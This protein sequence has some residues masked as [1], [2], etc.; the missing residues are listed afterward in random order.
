[1]KK[2]IYYVTGNQGKFEEVKYFIE[3]HTQDIDL[4]QFNAQIPEIQTLDQKTIALDKA[5]KAWE[6]LQ[7]PLIID[8][9]AIYFEKYNKFP[10]TFSKYVYQGLGFE[11]IKKLIEQKDK[12]TFFLYMIYV[13]KANSFNI[14]EGKCEGTLTK[15]EVFSG[16][17][18]LP[19][20]CFFIPHGT[21]KTYA[22]MRNTPEG[23]NY[24][25]RIKALKNFLNWWN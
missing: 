16:N 23:N 25:Y 13:E 6:I 15:P 1:M 2:K 3:Y 11:G 14:F 19:F 12:A 10:G 20:D 18:E 17:V 7:K 8:D 9:S 24:F 21:T 4:I 22:Q 5:L